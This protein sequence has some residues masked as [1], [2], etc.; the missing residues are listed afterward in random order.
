MQYLASF[1]VL[2][3]LAASASASP[4][5]YTFEV[6]DGSITLNLGVI[7]PVTVPMAG[8]FAMTVYASDGIIGESDTFL[9][10]DANLYNDELVELAFRGLVTVTVQPGG[11][12]LL[13]FAPDSAAHIPANGEATIDTDVYVDL[14]AVLTGA[15]DMTFTT[16]RWLSDSVPVDVTF[17][18]LPVSVSDM[19]T[20]S[21]GGTWTYRNWIPELQMSITIDQIV[22]IQARVIPDPGLTGLVALGVAGAS[23]WLRGRRS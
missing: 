20:V 1:A 21:L 6:I 16:S 7:T 2:C 5:L 10:G 17:D 13:D 15:V 14:T 12:N 22:D 9:L 18:S 19:F 3:L 11:A 23:A 4:V 8:T